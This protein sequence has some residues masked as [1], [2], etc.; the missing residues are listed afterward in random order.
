MWKQL[1]VVD[2]TGSTNADLISAAASG[3]EQ[4]Y[5]KV[6]NSQ[7]SGR[8]RFERV[9][10][11]PAGA[12]VAFSVLLRPTQQLKNWPWLSPAAAMAVRDAI[13]ETTQV[14]EDRVVL[15]WPNDIL[16]D[17]KKICGI[18][19]EQQASMIDGIQY[20]AAVVGIGINT[21]MEEHQLP[22][23]TAT[24]LKLAGLSVDPNQLVAAVLTHFANYYQQWENEG[25]LKA[26]YQQNL[27]TIG[28]EVRVILSPDQIEVGKAVGVDDQGCLI[29]EIAGQE[30]TFSAGDVY[31]LR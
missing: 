23:I 26:S 4:G 3:T 7:V 22:V 17:G 10:V 13:I 15:K 9:W 1:E 6:A 31:H 25:T 2:E 24:S 8:G 21:F 27:G 29:V 19:A 16:L 11:S 20:R 14:A 28:R 18:L 30:R 12:A 5:V